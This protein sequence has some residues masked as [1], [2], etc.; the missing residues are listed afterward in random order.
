[1]DGPPLEMHVDKDAK[2]FACHKAAKIPI[3]WGQEAYD[4]IMQEVDRD[5]IERVPYGEPMVPQT[6]S[7]QETRWPYALGRRHVEA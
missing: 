4:I 3:H 2:P 6:G 1:M 5:I 7:D